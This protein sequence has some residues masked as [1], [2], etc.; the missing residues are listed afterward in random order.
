M[1]PAV[2]VI[3]LL[4]KEG[5]GLWLGDEFARQSTGPLQWLTF[6]VFLNSLATI[7]FVLIQ[8]AG[9]PDLTAKFHMVELVV[10]APLLWLLIGR[11]GIEG[12]AIAWAT[13]TGMDAAFLM[14]FAQRFL[15]AGI[16]ATGAFGSPPQWPYRPCSSPSARRGSKCGLWSLCSRSPC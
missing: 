6:G 10:Y 4:G 2:L 8:A 7:P 5:L 11:Y 1:L 12:A 15:A 13:R 16:Q 14:V 3:I 9:R